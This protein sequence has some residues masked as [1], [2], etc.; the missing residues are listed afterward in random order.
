MVIKRVGEILELSVK[1]NKTLQRTMVNPQH[2]QASSAMDESGDLPSGEIPEES[3]EVETGDLPLGKI[4]ESQVAESTE[5]LPPGE[6]SVEE[7]KEED[8]EMKEAK[9]E[10]EV[11]Q[12]EQSQQEQEEEPDFGD[13]E[14]PES[15]LSEN[16]LLR[17]NELINLRLLIFLVMK[18]MVMMKFYA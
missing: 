7:A 12:D 15:E 4:P 6:I 2:E 3:M 16:A 14:H 5:D 8:V 13:E 18:K 9:D 1:K 10:E 11:P 17:V